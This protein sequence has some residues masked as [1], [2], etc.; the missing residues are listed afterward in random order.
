MVADHDVVAV[1]IN[2]MYIH[3]ANTWMALEE[4]GLQK[5]KQAPLIK[6]PVM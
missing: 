5:C 1:H 3:S 6:N 2:T 4:L